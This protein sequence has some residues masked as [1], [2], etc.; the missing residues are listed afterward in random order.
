MKN[1]AVILAGGIGYRLDKSYPKQFF[2]VAGKTVIEHTI[3]VF[4]DTK[5]I[6]EIVIVANVMY[7]MEI[8]NLVL[9]NGWKKVKNILI[10]GAYRHESSLS[11]IRA[12]EGQD[13]VN[14]IFHDAVRPLVSPCIINDVVAALDKY[15][16]VD[17]AVPATDTIIEVAGNVIVNI[18]D[19]SRLYRGQ[20][21]QG[22]KL[23]TIREAYKH[24]L[25]DPEFKATDDCGVVKKY[26]PNEQIFVVAGEES[27]MK[28]TY[29]EDTFLLDKHFQLRSIN[30]A[31]LQKNHAT[32]TGKTIVIFGG[33]SGI[34]GCI[35]TLC[36]NLGAK[37]CILSRSAGNTNIADKAAVKKELAHIAGKYGQIDFVINCAA[38]L[39]KETLHASDYQDVCNAI[40]TNYLGMVNIAIEAFPYLKASRGQLLLFT[41]SSYTRG[42]AF[43]S[44][45]SSTKAAAVNF[46]QALSQEWEPFGIKVNCMNPERTKTP[47]RTGNFGNEPDDTLLD[48]MLVAQ[49]SLSVLTSDYTGQV[50]DVK[51]IDVYEN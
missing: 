12:F 18:P 40:N 6:D 37:V 35:A 34:G 45:Y 42:R 23:H 51:K 14:L 16:A 29:K 36:T 9:K 48:P 20:T 39:L 41:S 3:T 31:S 28:L 33:N 10:G 24:A 15:N 2:K 49:A 50:I 26:L 11:A 8:E 46:M 47:M 27:N 17:V 19:R 21:P 25:Q 38:I 22:F 4:E 43:Y 44:I 1:I 13:N 5:S 7:L 30:S 32:I